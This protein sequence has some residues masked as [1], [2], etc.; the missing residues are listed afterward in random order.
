MNIIAGP[1]ALAFCALAVSLVALGAPARADEPSLVVLKVAGVALKPGDKVPGTQI[2]KLTDGQSVS[3]IGSDGKM[4]LLKGPYDGPAARVAEVK[5]ASVTD[6]LQP[7]FSK[8]KV[9][10][11]MPGVIRTATE[12]GPDSTPWVLD[13]SKGGDFCVYQTIG[14]DLWRADN[15]AAETVTIQSLDHP[16]TPVL[17]QF[18]AHKSRA[19]LPD[20]LSFADGEKYK[21]SGAGRTTEITAHVVPETVPQDRTAAAWFMT[22]NCESQARALLKSF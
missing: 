22:D 17:I 7:L 3:L 2:L 19:A 4:I 1:A 5:T 11:A 15:G 18:D 6:M 14:Y 13:V 16:A 8:A 12:A 10:T 21:L 9:E 20:S